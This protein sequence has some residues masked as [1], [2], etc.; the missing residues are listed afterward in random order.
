MSANQQIEQSKKYP[1]L[2]ILGS[3]PKTHDSSTFV[4]ISERIPLS[5]L[6][7]VYRVSSIAFIDKVVEVAEIGLTHGKIKEASKWLSQLFSLPFVEKSAVET[8]LSDPENQEI[9]FFWTILEH[10]RNLRGQ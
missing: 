1:H 8:W 10:W 3:P 2:T 5:E 4:H 7:R 6:E 9:F